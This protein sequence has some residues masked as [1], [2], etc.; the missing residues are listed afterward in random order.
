MFV[1]VTSLSWTRGQEEPMKFEN[2]W[3]MTNHRLGN[4]TSFMSQNDR[5]RRLMWLV[6]LLSQS[7]SLVLCLGA[8]PKLQAKPVSSSSCI[9]ETSGHKIWWSRQ[10][11]QNLASLLFAR[12]YILEYMSRN[13]VLLTIYT[14]KCPIKLLPW[15]ILCFEWMCSEWAKGS[16]SSFHW[17]THSTVQARKL[18]VN[19]HYFNKDILFWT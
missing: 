12:F 3:Q 1:Q 8:C 14:V 7:S 11:W 13:P 9:K 5:S 17:Y 2:C 19:L 15:N 6:S 4:E 10:H 18:M 16:C